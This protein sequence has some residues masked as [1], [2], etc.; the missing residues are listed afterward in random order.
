MGY[1]SDSIAVSRDMGPLSKALVEHLEARRGCVCVCVCVFL[2][3]LPFGGFRP[4]FPG[5]FPASLLGVLEPEECFLGGGGGCVKKGH[6]API[7]TS[8][9]SSLLGILLPEEVSLQGGWVW[10]WLLPDFLGPRWPLR[11]GVWFHV[12]RSRPALPFSDWPLSL[13]KGSFS[14]L[15]ERIPF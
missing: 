3:F 7:S 8:F 4:H 2:L 13:W 10:G 12:S 11:R 14:P 5:S 1:R 15:L 9:S 6:F